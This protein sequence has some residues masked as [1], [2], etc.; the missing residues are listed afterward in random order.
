LMSAQRAKF[1]AGCAERSTDKKTA[2]RVW[3]LM[4]KFA[5]YGF[6]KCLKGDTLIEMADG[7]TKP[8]VE[9]RAG[10][11]V[12]TKD[13]IFP[14]GPTRPSG[15]E[16]V[17]DH[18]PGLLGYALSEGSLGYD[19]HFYLHSTV[20]DELNDMAAIVEAFP[21]TTARIEHRLQ[22]RASSVRPVRIDRS[23]PSDAVR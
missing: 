13:G 6:N 12:L 10:D 18:L 23:T 15:V 2:E 4:E 14:A 3:E 7:T 21:N 11:R 8:I 9:I 17:P 22:G 19:S 20:A 5:G 16:T 1:V